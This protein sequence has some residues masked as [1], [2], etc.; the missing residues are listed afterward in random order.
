MGTMLHRSSFQTYTFICL[1]FGA[2]HIIKKSCN[3]GSILGRPRVP[4]SA[5]V[6]EVRLYR[7]EAQFEWVYSFDLN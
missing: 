3:D 5:G 4:S 7:L 1:T 2:D 6:V